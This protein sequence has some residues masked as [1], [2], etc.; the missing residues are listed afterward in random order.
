MSTTTSKT[1]WITGASSG[2]G[3][4]LVKHYLLTGHKVIASARREGEL[5]HLQRLY[6]DELYFIP[7]DVTKDSDIDTAKAAL[8]QRTK[9]LDLAILNAGTCEYL[10]IETPDWA[11]FERVNQVNYMGM[12]RSLQ[13]CLPLLKTT[14]EAHLV[15]VCSQAVQAP[16]IR[17]E[18]Y[19]ASKAAVRYLLDSL[20]LD[21]APD[22]IAV[23]CIMP[24]F[25]DTPLTQRNDFDMPFIMSPEQAAHRIE[26]AI[27]KRV[28][29]YAFP[30][31]LSAVLALARLFPRTWFKHNAR[32][33]S[34]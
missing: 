13:V 16:F 18:A 31:R 22:D 14:P 29:E 4:A 10:D 24:G 1:V 28:Y 12:V 25:I 17:S 32:K 15:G 20:R 21:L 9:R 11:L 34:K 19:G 7:F 3:L 27:S 5:K 8:E 26:Q 33:R 30:K 23:S 6:P 2:L